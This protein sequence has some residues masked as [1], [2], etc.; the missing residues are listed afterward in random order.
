MNAKRKRIGPR[1]RKSVSLEP[2]PLPW[3]CS[4]I[5][6]IDTHSSNL[7]HPGARRAANNGVHRYGQ[8]RINSARS[9][10]ERQHGNLNTHEFLTPARTPITRRLKPRLVI[11]VRQSLKTCESICA[12]SGASRM[13]DSICTPSQQAN[14]MVKT[15]RSI[16]RAVTHKHIHTAAPNTRDLI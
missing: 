3:S 14:K 5:A 9:P 12:D 16:W 11:V 2:Q 4:G 7:G 15:R 1:C 6:S 13:H 8:V 10:G